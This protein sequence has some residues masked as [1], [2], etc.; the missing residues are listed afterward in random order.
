MSKYHVQ[1]NDVCKQ[2]SCMQ[3]KVRDGLVGGSAIAS[4]DVVS[5][6]CTKIFLALLFMNS[7]RILS[8]Q[9]ISDCA[10]KHR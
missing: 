5:E 8:N 4:F 7:R 6:K 1:A 9:F 2:H 10:R 3:V